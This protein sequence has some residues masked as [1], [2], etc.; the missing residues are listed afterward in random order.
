MSRG[1]F[2]IKPGVI[3]TNLHV[4]EGMKR[5]LANVAAGGDQRLSFRIARIIAIDREA[6]LALLSVPTAISKS[7]APLALAPESYVPETGEVVYA[8][9]IRRRMVGSISP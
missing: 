4:I 2:F 8:L 5:G 7:I 6:D 9:E 1:G 3:V